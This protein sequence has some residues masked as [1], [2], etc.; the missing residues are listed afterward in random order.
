MCSGGFNPQDHTNAIAWR[1]HESGV[2]FGVVIVGR[3]S[4]NI[5]ANLPPTVTVNISTLGELDK[6]R[7]EGDWQSMKDLLEL[8]KL[9]D[10]HVRTQAHIL[11]FLQAKL[12]G[13][14]MDGIDI[15][16][17][18][19]KQLQ[20]TFFNSILSGLKTAPKAIIGT[21]MIAY[22]RPLMAATGSLIKGD[23]KEW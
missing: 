7:K 6:L 12:Y 15:Q 19:R 9:S 4:A 11:E 5:T 3:Y 2:Q 17:Q 1:M 23:R 20:S 10:G 22:S 13:G 8:E 16:G 18:T 14:R 21:N